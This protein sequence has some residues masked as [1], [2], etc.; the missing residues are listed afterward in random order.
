M[1]D[2]VRRHGDTATLARLGE[3][4]RAV[5]GGTGSLPFLDR[6]RA[7]IRA[8]LP[9]GYPHV[10]EVSQSLGLARRTLQRRLADRGISFSD[11]VDEVRRTV[12]GHYAGQ[13]HLPFSDL[14][15]LLGYSELSAFSRAFRRW[16]GV[17]P[18]RYRSGLTPGAP[19][20][21]GMDPSDPR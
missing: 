20:M 4:L 16:Y 21:A 5:A 14:A 18:R 15:A 3:R 9:E 2:A 7:E 6:V 13:R 17:A 19:V 10:E 11:L 1:A 12:A 8:R